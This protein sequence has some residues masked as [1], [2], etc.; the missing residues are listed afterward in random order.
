MN[1]AVKLEVHDPYEDAFRQVLAHRTVLLAT[2]RAIVR[3]PHRV[4]DTFS[5]VTLEIVRCWQR[6]D[7]S[8]PFGP[9]ARGVARRVALANLRKAGREVTSL[10]AEVLELLGS[11]LEHKGGES[12]FERYK[13]RLGECLEKLTENAQRLIRSRYFEQRTYAELAAAENKSVGALYVAFTRIHQ[14]L[15]RCLKRQ[16]PSP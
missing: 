16:P 3:D 10:D 8:R 12:L 11:D 15:A 1:F 5:D 2:V 9:W 7:Q 14:S 6:F 13:V 4:E